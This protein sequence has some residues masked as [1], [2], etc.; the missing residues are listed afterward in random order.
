MNTKITKIVGRILLII[1][2]LCVSIMVGAVV[3]GPVGHLFNV[4]LAFGSGFF[5]TSLIL[6]GCDE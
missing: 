1:T 5:G 6:E 2:G 3:P 4:L